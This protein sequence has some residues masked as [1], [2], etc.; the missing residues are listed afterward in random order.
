MMTPTL[1]SRAALA[2]AVVLCAG[3]AAM[4][5]GDDP[6]L[7]G[8]LREL[9]HRAYPAT[10]PGAAVIVVRDGRTVYR[11]AAGLAHLELDTPM[12]PDHVFLLFSVTKQFTGAAILLL[13]QDGLLSLSDPV[14][15]HLPDLGLDF[16]G[17]EVT[18][19]H[20]L[21]HTSGLVNYTDLDAWWATIHE[22]VDA[23]GLVSLFRDA[24]LQFEPGTRWEYNN[25]G[26]VL[27][28][29]IVERL[30]GMSYAEFVHARLLDPLDMRDTHVYNRPNA[31]VR[32]R[33]QGYS[34]DN[35]VWLRAPHFS[36]TH[37]YATGNM[38]SNVDDL[39]RWHA[40]AG[41]GRLLDEPGWRQAAKPFHLADG[42]D[43]HYAAGH[44]VGRIGPY[45]TLE[46]GGN[47]AGG[48]THVLRV[49]EAGLFVAVLA[50]AEPAP[51]AT[52]ED[53]AVALAARSLGVPAS[54]PVVAVPPARLVEYL[55][56]YR[57]DERDTRTVSMRDGVLVS[58]HS[59]GAPLRLQPIGEDL[60]VF[61]G[62]HTWL[63]FERDQRG[64][65]AM[66]LMPRVGPPSPRAAKER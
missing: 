66:R 2:L 24:P 9:F 10:D 35:G 14:E 21:S 26:Y 8:D 65:V 22:P 53:V 59:R 36:L 38:L 39:A 31:V 25:S 3:C 17:H 1:E 49:P 41:D 6:G 18:V 64:V 27:L 5:A 37:G 30:S 4:T 42:E 33:V 34:R 29:L 11:D 58:Q 56:V 48:L 7:A 15:R 54:P 20:L 60:F 44:Y 52:A 40:A 43:T 19:A 32:G 55:G 61:E 45:A 63:G 50:N 13:A 23:A 12:R 16:G 46:H 62:S 47:L 28:G 57:I 51:R